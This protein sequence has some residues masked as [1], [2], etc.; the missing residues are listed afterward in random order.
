M[1]IRPVIA[2]AWPKAD[3]LSALEQAGGAP[4]ILSPERDPL[5]EAL[6]GCAGVLLTGGEDVDPVHYGA[7]L[8]PTT[9]ASGERDAYELTLLRHAFARDLPVLGICRGAQL[10][11]V[12]AGGTL[13][14]DI[15]SERPDAIG[16]AV[17]HAPN[18]LAH[19]VTVRP[20]TRLASLLGPARRP[21]RCASTAAI[22]SR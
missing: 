17:R 8:H 20:D 7:D 22:T 21:R 19:D 14:Q 6:A 16:H 3:Y 11:N 13:M 1:E 15:P 9:S 10:L 2:V 5:P 18:A 12:A 4:R